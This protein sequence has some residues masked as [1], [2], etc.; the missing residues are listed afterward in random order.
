MVS[1]FED[2]SLSYFQF[3][4]LSIKQGYG[5]P[6]CCFTQFADIFLEAVSLQITAYKILH[7]FMMR[8]LY[9]SVSLNLSKRDKKI[10]FKKNK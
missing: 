9:Y 7:K 4:A 2:I 1:F 5:K 10:K 3:S 8:F 6:N